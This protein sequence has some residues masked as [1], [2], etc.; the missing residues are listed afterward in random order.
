MLDQPQQYKP[1]QHPIGPHN[2]RWLVGRHGYG[3]SVLT[4]QELNNRFNLA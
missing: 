2:H 1:Q 3:H 4:A